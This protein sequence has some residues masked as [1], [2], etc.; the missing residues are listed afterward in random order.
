M[1]NK[2]LLKLLILTSFLF[3]F[4]LKAA[5]LFDFK[6]GAQF[7]DTGSSTDLL[8]TS[9]TTSN[10]NIDDDFQGSVWVAFEH[11]IPLIPNIKLK[12]NQLDS[13]GDTVLTEDIQFGNIQFSAG[14]NVRTDLDMSNLDLMLYYEILNFETIW[15]DIGANFKTGGNSI[16]LE[17]LD[18][19]Q[20]E[21]ASILAVV[22]MAY[23]AA[24]TKLPFFGLG[25]FTEISYLS[26]ADF[27][28]MDAQ[29]GLNYKLMDLFLVDSTI[30]LGY[31]KF[32]INA[33][34]FD[35][36]NLEIDFDGIFLGFNATI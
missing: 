27:N 28:Y 24:G 33:D 35:G 1:N 3:S 32:N 20:R 9:A 29:I 11:P 23:A 7:W 31:R 10:L 16:V 13:T 34:S 30:E 12:A 14:E 4:N 15:L 22:P 2:I 18:S 25:A 6:A 5:F 17:S 36:N 8:N 19:N 26:I 21:E